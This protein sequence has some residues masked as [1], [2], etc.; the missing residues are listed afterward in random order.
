MRFFPSLSESISDLVSRSE[1]DEIIR[2]VGG[3]GVGVDAEDL[4][5]VVSMTG[6]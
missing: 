3:K 5:N 4:L 6:L 2:L 1:A